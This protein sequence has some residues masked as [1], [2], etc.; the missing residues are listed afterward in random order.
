[1]FCREYLLE[2]GRRWDGLVVVTFRVEEHLSEAVS[3]FAKVLVIAVRELI[4][5]LRQITSSLEIESF[6]VDNFG[7]GLLVALDH[8]VLCP[9]LPRGG[10]MWRPVVSQDGFGDNSRVSGRV[11][12]LDELTREKGERSTG[13]GRRSEVIL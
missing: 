5:N 2:S 8:V 3:F 6:I 1:M 12:L 7:T 10:R 11:A 9:E 13:G 4:Q